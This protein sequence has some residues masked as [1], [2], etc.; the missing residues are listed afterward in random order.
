MPPDSQSRPGGAS[1]KRLALNIAA[2][3]VIA[4]SLVSG[5]AAFVRD[6]R[7][8]RQA[9][10]SVFTD[11]D[12]AEM[13]AVRAATPP[14]SAI[15]VAF[16]RDA[17]WTSL[18]WQ[19]GLYPERDVIVRGEPISAT[20]IADARRRWRFT[21]AVAI[22][23]PPP[24]PGFAAHRDLGPIPGLPGRVRFGELAP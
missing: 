6:L 1:R 2:A 19:R 13:S 10:P 17:Q 12:R 8:S 24:D 14:G 15:L 16:G 18:L 3:A 23:D 9:G 11:R 5:G 22:G 4:A 7:V 21:H 20:A